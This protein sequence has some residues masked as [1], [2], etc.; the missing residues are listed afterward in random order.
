M[1]KM[2]KRSRPGPRT[3][4]A[5]S[6]P[7]FERLE[8]RCLLDAAPT[9]FGTADAF[10]Q[11]LRDTA[12]NNYKDLFGTHFQT[13][14]YRGPVTFVD[15]VPGAF[16]NAEDKVQAGSALSFSQTNVQVPGVDEGD[17]VKTDGRFIYDL[18]GQEEVILDANPANVHIVS[19]TPIEGYALAEYLNGSR[20]TVISTV[21]QS[22]TSIEPV[23]RSAD[24][25]PLVYPTY[26]KIK[27]TVLD[28]TDPTAPQV[29]AATYMDGTYVTSRAIG[30][31]IYIVDQ[32]Y[33][34][35]LPAP[36]YTSF[37]NEGIYESQDQYL[38]RISGHELDLSLPH[39]YTATGDPKN[40]LQAIGLV[41]D[42]A[43]IF[44][45]RSANDY[46]L[47]TVA[48]FDDTSNTPGPANSVSVLSSYAST[49]YASL[50]HLYVALPRW[51]NNGSGGSE[52]LQFTLDGSQVNLN[53]DGVVPGQ[54]INQFSMDEQGQ[55]FRIVTTAN[56]GVNAV[57][58]LYVFTAN[59]GTLDLVGS[60]GPLAPGQSERGVRFMGNTAFIVTF[61]GVD[62]LFAV[63]LSNPS[64]PRSVGELHF[65]GVD[66]YLQ[67]LD[68]THLLGVGRSGAYNSQL[69]LSLF[70]VSNISAP[71]LVDQYT[72]A[73]NGWSWWWGS[74]SE[75]EWDH[76]ALGYFPE[77]NTLAIPI[78]GSYVG[79]N[80]TGYVSSLWLFHIDPSKGFTLLGQ[81]NHDSQVRRSVRINDQLYSIA[82][83]SVQ[84]HPI[85]NPQAA[86]PDVR[87]HD[88]PRFPNNNPLFPFQN[89]PFS[90]EVVN[91]KV[92]DPTGLQ[93]TINWGDGQTSAGT[94][95]PDP[96]DSGRY[97][98]VGTHTYTKL[99]SFGV[100]VAFTRNGTSQDTL[101]TWCEVTA[102]DVPTLQFIHQLYRDLLHRDADPAG[103][104]TFGGFVQNYGWSHTQ[105]AS[106]I[107]NSAEYQT[108]QV[109]NMYTALL[110]RQADAGGL[111]GFVGYLQQG[112]SLQQAQDVMLASTE[113]FQHA[114]GSN[115]DFLKAL[116]HDVLG[117]S[118]DATGLAGFG[119]AL[120]SGA[121]R[122]DVAA[123]V[124]N[125]VEAQ[126]DMV[127][128]F[129][130]QSLHRTGDVTG[131]AGFTS[132][133]N[134]GATESQVL[135]MIMGSAEYASLAAR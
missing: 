90:G 85:Q 78:Y 83:D 41:A 117:R 82:D 120:A 107:E 24:G 51:D 111:N 4:T 96:D 116:Y 84:V 133:L 69:T 74:G 73:P 126:H 118:L 8:D 57:T 124:I 61:L 97:L 128:A 119:L 94:I 79:T 22:S 115:L 99:G 77:Y 15:N 71:T 59:G 121:P 48:V 12:L 13:Y 75:A 30:D 16:T 80:Y 21:Y 35:G 110:G 27:I 1:W 135:A 55:Y 43:L 125:S 66:S 46:N 19:R 122:A 102:V 18:N 98:V 34:A 49:V 26:S 91:F 108:M 64:T 109:Q 58:N 10:I 36:A 40:P 17:I 70:N 105:V 87:I 68:A 114:G 37:N 95:Q 9:Q 76:H 93:A 7:S 50:S 29:A 88:V 32:N 89:Q 28:V 113:Y 5:K 112:H 42:P 72:I 132:L 52:I 25:F 86:S 127:M 54:V 104:S 63:D 53:A 11:Y 23:V 130:Q 33:F 131:V 44:K 20:L 14:N 31:N 2:T 62:P 39:I 60:V 129:Y 38:A 100:N 106:A 81:I 45:P 101:Y 56:W 92:S 123:L 103:L 47:L 67:P 6:S 65:P 134:K 3:N